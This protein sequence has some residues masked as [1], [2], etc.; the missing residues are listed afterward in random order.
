MCTQKPFL[1]FHL[2]QICDDFHRIHLWWERFIWKWLATTAYFMVCMTWSALSLLFWFLFLNDML[3]GCSFCSVHVQLFGLDKGDL[4]RHHSRLSPP[5]A[6]LVCLGLNLNFCA[7]FTYLSY[8]F[9]VWNTFVTLYF[10]WQSPFIINAWKRATVNSLEFS[11]WE[12][13]HVILEWHKEL[14]F[15]SE[16]FLYAY[17]IRA[18]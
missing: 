8:G 7:Y 11:V 10:Y 17:T 1:I 2:H 16:L 6:D 4:R 15:S 9:V 18:L 12:D 5:D 13:S 3:A 14:S